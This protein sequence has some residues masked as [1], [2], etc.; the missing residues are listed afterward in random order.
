VKVLVL[1]SFVENCIGID[2]TFYRCLIVQLPVLFY[3]IVNNHASQS[4]H[5]S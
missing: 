3:N 4:K 1:Q 5:S 2:S